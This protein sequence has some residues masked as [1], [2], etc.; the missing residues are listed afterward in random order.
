MDIW[1]RG[2]TRRKDVPIRYYKGKAALFQGEN[3]NFSD[4][5]QTDECLQ[6]EWF[7]L[8]RRRHRDIL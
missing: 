1:R 8:T 3:E 4:E 2:I 5:G 7:C 6:T